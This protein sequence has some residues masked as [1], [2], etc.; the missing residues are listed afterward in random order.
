MT[1]NR[2]TALVTT[3][4]A[5][6]LAIGPMQVLTPSQAFGIESSGAG[7]PRPP[8][9]V[10]PPVTDMVPVVPSEVFRDTGDR[11]SGP[12]EMAPPID[13]GDLIMDLGEL[14]PPARPPLVETTK[15]GS[16]KVT[17]FDHNGRAVGVVYIFPNNEVYANDPAVEG[18]RPHLQ[19]ARVAGNLENTAW[20]VKIGADVTLVILGGPASAAGGALK[21]GAVSAIYEGAKAGGHT[22]SVKYQEGATSGEIV[23]EAAT[24]FVVDAT[25]SAA[26]D[27][28]FLG[29]GND[30]R[31]GI[32]EAQAAIDSGTEAVR[33][34]REILSHLPSKGKVPKTSARKV[35]NQARAAGVPNIARRKVSG[36]TI[37]A[38]TKI[39]VNRAR[40][41]I[42]EGGRDLVHSQGVEHV[43]GFAK[44]GATN[45]TQALAGDT[46]GRG[47]AGQ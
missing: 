41:Q 25:V 44:E 43:V 19:A 1:R 37:R 31:A 46:L 39:F 32:N 4:I 15:A 47:E 11:F 22:G 12:P 23:V 24:D 5:A 40:Q 30:V 34:G 45:A 18:A 28:V 9:M 21:V 36:R 26:M 35:I 27:V 13:I 6:L 10:R 17:Y 38:E 29:A 33:R 3:V 16:R 14:G 42:A 7:A 2:S 8:Q 20:V